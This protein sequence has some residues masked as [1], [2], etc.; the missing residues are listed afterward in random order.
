MSFPWPVELIDGRYAARLPNGS[1]KQLQ[2]HGAPV[3]KGPD[4]TPECV[5]PGFGRLRTIQWRHKLGGEGVHYCNNALSAVAHDFHSL[6]VTDRGLLLEIGLPELRRLWVDAIC[7]STPRSEGLGPGFQAVGPMARAQVASALWRSLSRDPRIIVLRDTPRTDRSWLPLSSDLLDDMFGGDFLAVQIR[8]LRE[9]ALTYG[10]LRSMSGVVLHA[11]GFQLVYAHRF[12]MK[13]G[14]FYLVCADWNFAP[15]CLYFPNIDLIIFPTKEH[16]GYLGGIMPMSVDLALFSAVARHHDLLAQYLAAGNAKVGAFTFYRHLGHHLWNELTGLDAAL[17]DN[18]SA[19]VFSV[20]SDRSEMFGRLDDLLGCQVDRFIRTLWELPERLYSE[21][22]GFL[23]LTSNRV[24]H[25]LRQKI[26]DVAVSQHQRGADGRADAPIVILGMRV[27]NRT[28]VDLAAFFAD[29]IR[30]LADELGAVTVVLDGHNAAHGAAPYDVLDEVGSMRPRDAE[31]SIW[32]DLQ[33]SFAGD[34]RV[35]IVS[36]L[37]RP[38]SE[39]I[40]WCTRAICFVAP[41][42][43]GLAKYRW[44]CNLPGLLVSNC[45]LLGADESYLYEDQRYME[46]P[47]RVYR[48]SADTVTDLPDAPQLVPSPDPTRWNFSVDMSAVRSGLRDLLASPDVRAR[49]AN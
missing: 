20:N 6:P 15:L 2:V 39:S 7:T 38:V 9:G 43:A 26:I 45:L 17:R 12:T 29:V 27:E 37:G 42:G 10:E 21:R 8:A 34:A 41:W 33:C 30:A 31:L 18:A 4:W 23:H 16:Q 25:S 22:I 48:V 46:T 1:T 14:A 19:E 44:V 11:A 28:V 5:Y 35:R 36:T 40:A 24:T 47:T 49:K 3:P 32:S 13:S